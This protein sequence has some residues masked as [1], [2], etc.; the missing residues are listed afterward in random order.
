MVATAVSQSQTAFRGL[1]PFRARTDLYGVARLL[2]E[3][4]RGEHHFPFADVPVLREIGIALWTLGYAPTFPET[5]EGFVWIE[6]NRIVGNVTFTADWARGHCY[7][8]SNVAVKREYQRR[9][10]AR[11]MMRASLEHIRRQYAVAVLL[12]VRP[13]NTGAIRLYEELGFR[14]LETRGQ[15]ML[16]LMPLHFVPRQVT[17]LR[18]LGWKDTRAVAEL[19]RVAT[20]ARAQPFRPQPNPFDISFDE[21]V[22]EFLSDG[23]LARATQRWVLERDQRI[24]AV[25]FLRAHYL[26]G[27][28]RL[29]VE[30]HPDFRGRVEEE[31]LA[32]AF[33]RL[34]P[35]GAR[36]IRADAF[37][38]YPEWIAT[39]ERQGFRFERGM[40]LMELEI[41]D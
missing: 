1:R 2:Q 27:A 28:H 34:A 13:Q 14:K 23:C 4:F 35:F 5:L 31:L 16:D 9:G 38:T 26:T 25:L 37:S 10:I 33:Q 22:M 7:Y 21:R 17:G 3:A 6:D 30:T 32:A 12:N 29:A 41:G 20:P 8:I 18:P 19:V 36:A 40:T 39:L 15:W 11:A 24:A